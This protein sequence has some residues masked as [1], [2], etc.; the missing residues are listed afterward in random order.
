M[1]S[2]WIV[3]RRARLAAHHAAEA[4]SIV[5]VTLAQARVRRYSQI[6]TGAG[7]RGDGRP[8]GFGCR[9]RPIDLLLVDQT[10]MPE[11]V[12]QEAIT[13]GS[14]PHR[15]ASTM[16]IDPPAPRVRTRV[17]A[18]PRTAS[19]IA[20]VDKCPNAAVQSWHG[21]HFTPTARGGCPQVSESIGSGRGNKEPAA[22]RISRRNMESITKVNARIVLIRD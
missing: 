3:T 13:L 17:I 18:R 15:D 16:G 10:P 6:S 8:L 21:A 11:R 20:R 4:F 22:R 7:R 9:F 5:S 1:R 2:S 12:L 14:D 19:R